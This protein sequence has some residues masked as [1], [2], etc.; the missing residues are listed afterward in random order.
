MKQSKYFFYKE[1]FIKEPFCFLKL[2]AYINFHSKKLSIDKY[3]TY[4]FIHLSQ[5]FAFSNAKKELTKKPPVYN[6]RL[7]E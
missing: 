7:K 1:P 5:C 3:I 2:K 4:Y 6:N